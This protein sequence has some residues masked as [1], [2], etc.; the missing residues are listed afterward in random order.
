MRMHLKRKRN[1]P[2]LNRLASPV[3]RRCSHSLRA[4]PLPLHLL[5]PICERQRAAGMLVFGGIGIRLAAH[6]S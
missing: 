4:H 2:K 1:V 5:P 6:A 3:H